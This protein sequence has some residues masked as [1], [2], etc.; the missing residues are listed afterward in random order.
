MS[1]PDRPGVLVTLG[2]RVSELRRQRGLTK[3]GFAEAL[4]VSFSWIKRVERGEENLTVLTLAGFAKVLGV[5]LAELFVPAK[6]KRKPGRPKTSASVRARASSMS[7]AK[8][9]RTRT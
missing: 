6:T 7:T 2:N 1:R 3:E 8:R 5:K 4:D 9:K